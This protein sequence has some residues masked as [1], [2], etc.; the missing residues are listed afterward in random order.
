MD[1]ADYDNKIFSLLKDTSTYK[2]ITHDPTDQF[3]NNIINELKQL[4][5]NGKITP[6]LYNKFY[7]R[8]SFC[9]KFYGL[10]KLHKQGI[11]LRPIVA[12]TKTP[13]PILE[14]GF[15]QLSNLYCIR[16]IPTS[17]IRQIW[18]KNLITQVFQKTQ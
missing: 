12:C 1:T 14:N 6:Q 8:G 5:Q 7:P 3:T 18:L 2:P 15:A 16:K 10:P 4:K 9:P 11:P 13:L 17:V